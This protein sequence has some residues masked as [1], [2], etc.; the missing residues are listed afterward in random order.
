MPY[1]MKA[2]IHL[3]FNRFEC[4]AIRLAL[5]DNGKL[6]AECATEKFVAKRVYDI[7]EGLLNDDIAALL[8]VFDL[9]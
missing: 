5:R 8:A 1:D 2:T 9:Q 6:L 4:P 3:L 7:A